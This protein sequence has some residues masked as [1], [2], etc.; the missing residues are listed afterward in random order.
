ME[1]GTLRQV[2]KNIYWAW[3]SIKQ[4]CQ[5]KKCKAYRN[6]GERGIK[7]YEEWNKFEPFCEWALSH[8]YQKGLD[9]DRIDNNGDY[10]PD[11]CHWT[12]RRSNLNNRRNTIMLTVNGETKSRTEWE[13][14]LHLPRGIVK[15]WVLTTD[16]EYAEKRLQEV[17][18]IGYKEKDYSRNH[19][20]TSVKC[21]EN[22]IIYPS[23]FEASKCLGLNGGAI[24][25]AAKRMGT[26]GGYHFM[27]ADESH[28]KK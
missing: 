17:I 14:F 21:L 4:R 23:V 3:K 28:N 25:A 10:D 13:D 18:E 20:H 24:L 26:A 12:S 8:G 15:S 27:L 1:T 6:Y 7:V 22:G 16:K 9:I 5:N 11:N 19:K 2:N